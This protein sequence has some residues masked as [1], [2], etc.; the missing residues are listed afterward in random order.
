MLDTKPSS[1]AALTIDEAFAQ[2]PAPLPT[3]TQG[4]SVAV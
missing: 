1:G 4:T 3:F 2:L